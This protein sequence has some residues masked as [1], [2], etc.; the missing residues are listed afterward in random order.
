MAALWPERCAALVAVSGYLIG[1]VETNQQ[2]L[3]PKAELGWWYLFYFATERGRLG[4]RRHTHEFNRLIW[5]LASPKWDFTGATFERTAASFDNPDHVDIVIHNY[6]W[7]L[8]LAEG[9]QRYLGFERRLAQRP[10]IKVPTITIG[11]D[12]DGANADGRVYADRFTGRYEHRILDGIGHNVPQEAPAAF[13]QA[14]I[15]LARHES[16]QAGSRP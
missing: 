1:S 3:S 2:P 8:G 15:E 4:Y 12:F 9:E 11:S 10:T 16:A 6:R 5:Q 13:A 14:V 7:R